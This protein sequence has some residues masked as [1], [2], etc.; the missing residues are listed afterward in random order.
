MDYT[1]RI[2]EL[3]KLKNALE[4][5]VIDINDVTSFNKHVSNW[6]GK[7]P[8]GYARLLT[9][10]KDKVKEI[11]ETKYEVLEVINRRITYLETAI[12]DQFTASRGICYTTYDDDP[13]KNRQKQISAINR[14]PNLD[15]SVRSRLLRLI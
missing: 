14:I 3:N 2:S 11:Y 9:S 1:S 8:D 7:S 15:S 6:T 4:S 5:K 12:E 10:T 13:R